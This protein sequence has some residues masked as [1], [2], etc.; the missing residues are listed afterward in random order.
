MEHVGGRGGC[1]IVHTVA[2]RWWNVSRVLW[3]PVAGRCMLASI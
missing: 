1:D 3:A 2:V